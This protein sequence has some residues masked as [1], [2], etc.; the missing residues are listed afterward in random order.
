MTRTSLGDVDLRGKGTILYRGGWSESL[1][2]GRGTFTSWHLGSVV[3]Q[4]SRAGPTAL[5]VQIQ[6]LLVRKRPVIN[7]EIIDVAGE[8]P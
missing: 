1:D 3:V 4:P 6:Y 7:A 2:T 8:A 5:M